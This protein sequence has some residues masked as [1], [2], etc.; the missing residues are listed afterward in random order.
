[1]VIVGIAVEAHL[2]SRQLEF[3]DQAIGGEDLQVAIDRSQADVRHSLANRL[4]N[5][6]SR[7]MSCH[8]AQL[9]EDDLALLRHPQPACHCYRTP[10]QFAPPQW[11]SPP[12]AARSFISAAG[13]SSFRACDGCLFGNLGEQT[14]NG[15]WIAIASNY[16]YMASDLEDS[17]L[18]HPLIFV[19]EPDMF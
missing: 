6:V 18:S 10:S 19:G 7:W 3:L 2:M 1:M 15:R 8:L 5:L 16:G 11:R 13:V 12:R 14:I 9:F 4:T 17:N